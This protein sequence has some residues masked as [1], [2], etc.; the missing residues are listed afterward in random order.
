MIHIWK[1]ITQP[2]QSDKLESEDE[3]DKEFAHQ[4]SFIEAM[5]ESVFQLCLSCL[6]LRE[7][8]IS[9]DPFSRFIQVSTFVFSILSISIAFG[10]VTPILN[11]YIHNYIYL[12][13][14][15]TE[16]FY[17]SFHRDNVLWNMKK[18]VISSV[19]KISVHLLIGCHL[20]QYT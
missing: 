19:R 20:L 15:M 16:N 1:F 11:S 6:I 4:I 7:F 17:F 10:K 14:R 8:G 18:Y 2:G 5:S 9:A 3:K 13:H 12:K